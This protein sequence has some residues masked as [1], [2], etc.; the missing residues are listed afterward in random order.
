VPRKHEAPVPVLRGDEP[1][2]VPAKRTE[3]GVRGV[4]MILAATLIVTCPATTFAAGVPRPRPGTSS[5][6]AQLALSTRYGT[7]LDCATTTTPGFA[8]LRLRT[9]GSA[10]TLMTYACIESDAFATAGTVVYDASGHAL[11]S[12]LTVGFV[13]DQN[14]GESRVYV[15]TGSGNQG[16]DTR[17]V[18]QGPPRSLCPANTA[19]VALAWVLLDQPH[20]VTV[21]PGTYR[22]L[23]FATSAHILRR[24]YAIWGARGSSVS[25]PPL[26][27]STAFS[28]FGRDFDDSGVR[29]GAYA[30]ATGIRA[31]VMA[32][33]RITIRHAFV[34]W[35]SPSSGYDTPS[36]TGDNGFQRS[37]AATSAQPSG[38]VQ[39]SLAS[40]QMGPGNYTLSDTGIGYGVEVPA[41]MFF[42]GVDAEL[43]PVNPPTAT[44]T[45]R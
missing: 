29:A 34:G 23:M 18:A 14:S 43:P 40:D 5:P 6:C 7:L 31:A 32:T 36:I 22:G 38:C 44:R 21:P 35:M 33:K 2:L 25:T 8:S 19:E 1:L 41:D 13:G 17:V 24:G 4:R 27:G 37:C 15:G 20:G 12:G 16:T 30:Q 9:T 10:M 26:T 3:G 28:M 39:T 42:V 11:D 45:R